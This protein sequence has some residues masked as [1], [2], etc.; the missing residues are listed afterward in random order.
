M[1]AQMGL[2]VFPEL[3]S[4]SADTGC[5]VDAGGVRGTE[6]GGGFGG[7]RRPLS[8]IKVESCGPEKVQCNF[9]PHP[10]EKVCTILLLEGQC[11]ADSTLPQN[12]CLE[13]SEFL[14]ALTEFKIICQWGKEMTL[15]TRLFFLANAK[16]T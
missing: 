6:A 8:S 5:W 14:K 15:K 13:V 2:G 9:K 12:T 3:L 16:C 1:A 4:P 7:T 11:L 10:L